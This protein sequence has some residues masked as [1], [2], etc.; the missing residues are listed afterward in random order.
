MPITKNNGI[1]ICCFHICP[2]RLDVDQKNPQVDWASVQT[3]RSP[4]RPKDRIVYHEILMKPREA[5]PPTCALF[6]PCV[7]PMPFLLSLG[8]QTV[9]RPPP[10][11]SPAGLQVAL[12]HLVQS[13]T[14]WTRPN[15]NRSS[16]KCIYHKNIKHWDISK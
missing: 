9:H 13:P 6:F 3:D 8:W 7:F 14:L 2:K 1:H 10:C 15:E 11:F 16:A 5:L 12:S 4:K